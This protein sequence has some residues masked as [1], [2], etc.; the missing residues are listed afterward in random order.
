MKKRRISILLTAA[1]ICS[2][3]TGLGAQ[4]VLAGEE[5]AYDGTTIRVAMQSH[6]CTDIIQ[7][8]L[9]EFE[10]K[11]GITVEVDVIP[12][13]E[14]IDKAQVVLASG[15][16][17]YD[18]IMYDHMYT[19]QF[20]GA[21]WVEDL[22]PYIEKTG[23]DIE[24][25][26][27][28]FV[29]SLSY[30]GAIYGIPIYGESSILMYNTELF[31]K[32]GIDGAPKTKEE[33]DEA[34]KKLDEAGIPA[35]ALRGAKGQGSNV[36]PWTGMFLEMGGD[37]FDSDGNLAVNS[38]AAVTAL[39]YYIDLMKNHSLE[40]VESFTWDQVQLAMQ[41]A[42]VAMCIDATNFSSRL[43]NEDKSTIVG[44]VGYAV[45]PDG[46]SVGWTAT[47]G[48]CIPT[49]A[50]NKDAGWEF[51]Q[52]ALD[53]DT[54]LTSC[55]EGDRCDPT[56]ISV[57]NSAEFNE[58]YNYAEGQWVEQT[59]AALD[60]CPPDYR[61]RI[62]EWPELG[63]AMGTAISSAL[64][65]DDPQESLNAVEEQFSNLEDPNYQMFN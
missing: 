39:N 56:R 27:P 18:V 62:A 40:G 32:A 63:E 45:V 41:Q 49:A 13:E 35:I 10:E 58:R 24:D 33:F 16:S 3:L 38:E 28:G 65:G 44:K 46:M 12:Q 60:S 30:D 47:W 19:T 21:Q 23:Y 17:D 26:M 7:Q 29:D 4:S 57:M 64:A 50:E 37:W 22:N 31:E 61:P 59:L 48:L 55:L 5:K 54:Q 8:L 2:A 53:G 11:T 36:Q 9:P 43:E 42:K 52:W 25:F 51:I 1:M 34:I 14:I 20:A 15:S 6:T